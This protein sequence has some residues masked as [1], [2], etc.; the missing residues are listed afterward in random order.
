MT[1]LNIKQ[2]D[3]EPILEATLQRNGS[4]YDLTQV[5][6]PTV[7]FRMGSTN[8][9]PIVENTATI[10]DAANGEVQYEWTSG[11]TDTAGVFKSE[12]VVVGDSIETTFPSDGY[13]VI[14]IQEE[15]Q[16]T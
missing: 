9:P 14:Y 11:D 5:S 15:I 13:F 10:V 6:N 3:T 16:E 2:G 8:D 4:A 1:D 7:T 12:F